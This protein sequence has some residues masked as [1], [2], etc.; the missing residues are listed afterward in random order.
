MGDG[1]SDM[2]VFAYL[3]EEGELAIGVFQGESSDVWEVLLSDWLCGSSAW[4]NK[5]VGAYMPPTVSI[6]IPD[7]YWYQ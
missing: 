5:Y 7:I 6:S 2:P 3:K 1:D 4:M